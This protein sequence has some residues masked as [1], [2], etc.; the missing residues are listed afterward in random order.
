MTENFRRNFIFVIG[1][2]MRY[3]RG[4]ALFGLFLFVLSGLLP[5][6]RVKCMEAS[7]RALRHI[8][9]GATHSLVDTQAEHMLW[10]S[11]V[12]FGIVAM[13][14]HWIGAFASIASARLWDRVS[15]QLEQRLF[16]HTLALPL[17]QIEQVDVSERISRAHVGLASLS[18]YWD[19]ALSLFISSGL[20]LFTLSWFL[21]TVNPLLPVCFLV[22]AV[23]MVLFSIKSQQEFER[24]RL[25]QS[26]ML[27]Q[28]KYYRSLLTARVSAAEIRTNALQEYFISGW[29]KLSE[30]VAKEQVQAKLSYLGTAVRAQLWP[31]AVLVG[32]LAALLWSA[33]SHVLTIDSTIA[34][35]YAVQQFQSVLRELA[36]RI[37]TT[38]EHQTAIGYTAECLVTALA[39]LQTEPTVSVDTSEDRITPSFRTIRLENVAYTYP[40]SSQ[41]ALSNINLEINWPERIA[42]VGENGAGKSTLAKVILGLYE[43][44]EGRILID[45]VEAT[46]TSE[47]RRRLRTGA[48]F[49]DFMRYAFTVRENIGL[50]TRGRQGKCDKSIDLAAQKSGVH[51]FIL[52]LPEKYETLLGKQFEHGHDLSFGQ[53]QMLAISRCYASNADLIVLD[54]PSS[55]LDPLAEHEVFQRFY[56]VMTRNAVVQISHRMGPARLCDRI[57]YL[58]DGRISEQGDHNTLMQLMGN[59]A[60]LYSCQAEWYLGISSK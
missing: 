49:Q 17:E 53:W 51:K 46:G 52:E 47:A 36:A 28:I 38:L 4:P 30:Q 29:R 31:I 54:E 32:S 48:V 41:P 8:H 25:G 60:H 34:A 27:R 2:V 15:E 7:V 26:P 58:T 3:A 43:P 21:G 45:G 50:G 9:A 42:L 5:L 40:G 37:S 6:A 23:P 13:A 55:A 18:G 22:G 35:V 24:L 16:R 12:L 19:N 11:L 39:P 1:S 44:T 56:D 14:T 33:H 10:R 57:I 20:S 59:Y